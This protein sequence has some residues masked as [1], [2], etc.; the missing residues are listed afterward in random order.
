MRRW[1]L[2]QS[3]PIF[4]GLLFLGSLIGQ[5]FAGAAAY[6]DQ[7]RAE[8]FPVVSVADYVT[9]AHF[10]VDVAENW[11][12]EYLQFLVF[13]MATV[14]LVQRGSTESKSLGRPGEESDKDQKLG[15]YVETDSPG[16]AKA[17]GWRTAVYS[18]SL[19]LVMGLV[20]LATWG[21]QALAGWVAYNQERLGRM[22]DPVTWPSY[23]VNADFWN[24]SLQNWQSE[25]LAVGTMVTFSV[26]LRQR[27][28]AQSKPV[29]EPHQTTGASG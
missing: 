9:S 4:F 14:W 11:Q 22:Q 1:V 19:G 12:S 24:R 18:R 6:N 17:G 25:F 16:L 5:A 8:G 7:Q 27:G 29:G 15:Y 26:F 13:V 2:E 23:L 28:S 10:A 20:F 3:L 21:A